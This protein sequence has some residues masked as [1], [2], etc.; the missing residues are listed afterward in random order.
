MSFLVQFCKLVIIDRA[1][2]YGNEGHLALEIK[3]LL[4]DEKISLE[5]HPHI[6]GLGGSDVNY[7]DIAQKIEEAM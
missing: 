4:F 5:V 3:A 7:R 2:S 1:T 6:M